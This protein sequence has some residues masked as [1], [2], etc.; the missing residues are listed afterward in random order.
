VADDTLANRAVRGTAFMLLGVGAVLVLSAGT[1][2][3]PEGWAFLATYGL[4]VAAMVV[5]L[6]RTDPALVARRMHSG[7]VAE[8]EPRQKLIQAVTMSA[9]LGELVVPGLDHRF[10]WSHVPLELVILGHV[11]MIAG[12][13]GVMRVFAENS[14]AS[15]IIEVAAGQRVVDTGPYAIV[16]HPMYAVALPGIIAGIPLALASWWTLLLVVPL[17]AAIVARLVDEEHF[18]LA[19]LPGYADYCRRLRWRLVPGVW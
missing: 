6:L 15:S 17:T 10:G 7:P 19:N 9:F 11:L 5:T 3:W 1:L 14:Y 12:F 18:L 8:R 16:R 2:A 4:C 13:A